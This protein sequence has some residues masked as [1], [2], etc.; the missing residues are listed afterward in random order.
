[1]SLANSPLLQVRGVR[2]VHGLGDNAVTALAGVDLV[3]RAGEFMA[4]VGPSGSGKSSLLELIGA[5]DTPDRG[6][7][8]FDGLDLRALGPS[9]R[10]ALRLHRLGFVFQSYN[11]LPVLSALENVDYVL[12]LQKRSSAERRGRAQAMLA[13]VGL[14]RHMHRRPDELSGGQQQRVAVARALVGRPQLVLAD[15]PTANLDSITGQHIIDLMKELNRKEG[16]TFIFSTH[17]PQVMRHARRIVQLRDG[18]IVE[19]SADAVAEARRA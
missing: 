16:T 19:D 8:V 15:E 7:V 10:A 3:V 18:R 4:L 1:M 6:S 14:E 9:G 5:L 2:R 13:A 17:D 11:L 12:Q